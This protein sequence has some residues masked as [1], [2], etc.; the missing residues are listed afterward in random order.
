MGS[1]RSDASRQIRGRSMPRS[2]ASM[3]DTSAN[4]RNSLA[5]STGNKAPRTNPRSGSVGNCRSRKA[6]APKDEVVVNIDKNDLESPSKGKKKK[7]RKSTP[8]KNQ[9][10]IKRKR[11]A[12]KKVVES[13]SEEEKGESSDFNSGES[14]VRD[15]Q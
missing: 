1:A 14:D 7:P 13:E 5:L 10:G 2:D 11:N 8:R 15:S 4:E 12:K 3:R 6:K 9:S